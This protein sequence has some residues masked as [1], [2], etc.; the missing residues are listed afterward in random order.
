MADN[1][2]STCQVCGD[3]MDPEHNG[4]CAFCGRF[5]HLTWDTRQPIK[6]CGKFDIDD[7]TLALYFT[8]NV[9]LAKGS[10]AQPASS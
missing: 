9:C 1:G 4:Y 3:P 5:F 7:E 8:C 2:P 10:Q 6:D